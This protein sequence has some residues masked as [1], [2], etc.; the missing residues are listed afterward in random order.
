MYRHRRTFIVAH[1]FTLSSGLLSKTMRA[2]LKEKKCDLRKMIPPEVR[3][4]GWFRCGEPGRIRS[5][6][7]GWVLRAVMIGIPDEISRVELLTVITST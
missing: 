7:L 4:A 6:I 1:K 3:T 2:L 5:V